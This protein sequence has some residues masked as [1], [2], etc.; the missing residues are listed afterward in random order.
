M[1]ATATGSVGSQ[2]WSA[3][4]GAVDE[5]PLGIA[6]CVTDAARGTYHA[7]EVIGLRLQRVH[8]G[9]VINNG[10]EQEA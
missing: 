1:A 10:V 4:M 2:C 6:G 9:T 7:Q 3:E 5:N 8:I